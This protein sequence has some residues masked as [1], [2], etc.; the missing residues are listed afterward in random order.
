ME[1]IKLSLGK[2]KTY[3]QCPL[4]YKLANL[5]QAPASRKGGAA[6]SFYK[7]TTKALE[8]F[9][10][11]GV[12]ILP[13]LTTLLELYERNWSSDGF[14][15][16]AEEKQ[17]HQLGE[18]CMRKFYDNFR[19]TKP[20]PKYFGILI[21][22]QSKLASVSSRIDRVD[23]L[24]DGTYEVI[25]YKT[26]K[27]ALEPSDLAQD[28][29]AVVLFQGANAHK[30]FQGK[31]SR[32]SFYYLRQDRKVSATPT[33]EDIKKVRRLIDENVEEIQKLMK[34]GSGGLGL[35]AKIMPGRKNRLSPE[36]VAEG[37][38]KK[39]PLC[40]TCEYLDI[41]P[42]WP[43][44]PREVVHETPEVYRER[45]RLSY[46][47]LSSYRRCPRAWKRSYLDG[48]FTQ[49]SRPFFSFG[50]AVHDTFEHFYDPLLSNKPTLKNLLAL[51]DKTFQ[52][53]LKGYA[54]K[55]EE[56]KYYQR[57]LEMIKKYFA[58]YIEGGKF[59]PAYAV[60]K[61][62]ELPLGKNVIMTGY[63]DRIDKLED[64]TC[65]ILDYKTEHTR[66]LQ[67]AVDQDDQLTIYFWA[68]ETIFQ[69]KIKQ[70]ALLMLYFD[71]KVVTTRRQEDIPQVVA[72]IDTTA[73]EIKENV[74]RHQEE[75]S[76]SEK[77]CSYFPPQKNKYCKGCDFLEDCPLRS[78]IM[79]DQDIQ[80][81]E[82]D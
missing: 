77:E 44:K 74:R 11:Q 71:E 22:L 31:V 50:N 5:D 82:Y 12:K 26:G 53:Y 46:S 3:R 43:L 18:D 25:N 9:H 14:K 47:K 75:H 63:I 57:G 54:D 70:M 4:K 17:Y 66:R 29:Q 68:C 20:N 36:E 78:E 13:A 81:M 51:W 28:L 58:H 60:E 1:S 42:A 41:C 38:A 56:A 55:K 21:Y 80:G 32:V 49:K 62:F 59:R 79:G 34:S 61:Y 6:L 69:L 39:G 33:P 45:L 24:P 73:A 19:R 23:L 16:K 52:G 30:R 8:Y 48:E 35:L 65:E 64:G 27:S 37:L 15:D 40:S 72:S 7:A 67:E 76:P 2:L 10:K